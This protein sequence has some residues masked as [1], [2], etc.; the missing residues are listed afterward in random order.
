V[1]KRDLLVSPRHAMLLG[2]ALVPAEWLVNGASIVQET[3]CDSVTYLHLELDSHDVL[4]A[5]GA[6]SESFVDCDSRQLFH[7]AGEYAA[8][9]PDD[10][11]SDWRLCAPLLAEASAEL[12][13]IRARLAARAGLDEVCG[14]ASAWR[15]NLEQVSQTRVRGWAFDSANP[16][17]RVRL[18]VLVDG[19][20]IGHVL[21]NR[22]RGD[23]ARAGAYGDGRH[24]FDFRL[25]AALEPGR[26]V[27]VRRAAD[28]L[29]LPGSPGRIAAEG[30]DAAAR[31][32]LARRLHGV[33][34]TSRDKALLEDLAGFLH[35]EAES[36]RAARALLDGGQR[37]EVEDPRDPLRGLALAGGTVAPVQPLALV[38]DATADAG[39]LARMESLQRL[40]F[41][42]R[43]MAWRQPAGDTAALSAAGIP[44]LGA[45]W[46][47]VE[48]VLRRLGDRLDLVL[49]Q[50]AATA[51]LYGLLARRFCPQARIVFGATGAAGGFEHALAGQLVDAVL[52]HGA[53]DLAA[54]A[55]PVLRRWSSLAA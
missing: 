25:P 26:S 55:A 4:L 29:A 16:A 53:D 15:G 46:G 6:A 44:C 10:D 54:A 28:A 41:Q 27:E 17:T 1:P 31:A 47:G 9:Y 22:A 13:V 43:F 20:L 23:L 49:L 42:L 3:G 7:N 18:D 24:G 11:A 48:E 40:G 45:A 12:A 50:G 38:L 37:A 35:G 39:A 36:L 21:A 5:E 30:F 52:P 14:P 19:V 8:L 2:G 32:D 51:A 33:A 34:A